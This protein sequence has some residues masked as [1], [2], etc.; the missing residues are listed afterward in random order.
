MVTMK[1]QSFK[2]AIKSKYGYLI[3]SLRLLIRA[4]IQTTS[5]DY[6]FWTAADDFSVVVV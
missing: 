5:K 4:L 2:E 6:F 3:A 1:V